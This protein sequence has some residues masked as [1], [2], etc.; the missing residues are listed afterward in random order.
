MFQIRANPL[1]VGVSCIRR[2]GIISSTDTLMLFRFSWPSPKL[3]LKSRDARWSNNSDRGGRKA[4][5]GRKR[6]CLFVR[7]LYKRESS[8]YQGKLSRKITL[9]SWNEWRLQE[10]IW[11]AVNLF[12]FLKLMNKLQVWLHHHNQFLNSAHSASYPAKLYG[13]PSQVLLSDVPNGQHSNVQRERE[14]ERN[15]FTVPVCRMSHRKWRETKQ[16]QSRARSG[17]QISLVA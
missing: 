5:E 2:H 8:F 16:Q 9:P 7:R 10:N 12:L 15:Y 17:H 14:R 1:N 3:R 4:Q 13:G 11:F 6:L